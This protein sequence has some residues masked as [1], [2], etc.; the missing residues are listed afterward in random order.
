MPALLLTIFIDTVGFGIVLPLLPYFAEKFDASPLQVTLLATVYSIAQFLLAPLWGRLSDRWGRRPI[1]L[2]T[3]GGLVLG[4]F[5]LTLADSLLALFLAR[6]FTG[7]MA[8]NNGVVSA[9]ITD[10]TSVEDRARGMGRVGAAHGL[11]FIVGPA[12]GG[13]FAGADPVNPDLQ[14]PFLI[15]AGLS[16]TALVIAIVQLRETVTEET[17]EAAARGQR[18]PF[19]VFREAIGLPQLGLLLLLLTMTP[20]VFSAVETT[21][22]MWSERAL[23][24]GP[25]QNGQIYTFMGLVAAATQWFLVGR[26]TKR[27]GEHRLIRAGAVLIGIGVFIL[28]FMTGPA[29]LCLAFGFIVFGVSINNPSLNSLISQYASPGERGSLLGV[30]SSCSALARITGPAWG[31]FAFGAFGRDWP[32]LSSAVVMLLMLALALRLKPRA[33]APAGDGREG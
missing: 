21:F 19:R 24:W 22:V 12:I 32:F 31:G 7:A 15:A 3:L 9:Y 33:I 1:I 8:S 16:A 23:G 14:L 18:S 29:G 10:I 5:W 17:R 20:F 2:F 25:L 30:S 11:G 27:F 4:Y 26:L 6:A 13:L 28:P